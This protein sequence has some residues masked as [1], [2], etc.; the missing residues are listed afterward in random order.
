MWD[1]GMITL[2]GVVYHYFVKHFKAGS[3]FGIDDGKISKLEI[4]RGNTT[5]VHYDREW[6]TRPVTEIETTIYE[7]LI[8]LYN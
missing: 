8:K 7:M 2:D 3:R 4:R 1:E 5:C 6:I